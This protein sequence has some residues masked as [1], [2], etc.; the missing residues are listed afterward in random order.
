M[1]ILYSNGK[2]KALT[3]S[4]DDNQV[5][6]RKLLSMM[7]QYNLK[8]T[9]HVNAGTLAEREG[10]SEYITREEVK[11]LYHGHE[12][13]C[14]GY[15]HPFMGQLA[16][17]ELLYEILEEKKELEHLLGYPIRGM[18]YPF[19]EY[20]NA[21]EQTALSLGIEYSRTVEDTHHFGW[22]SEFMEWHPSFHHN[23]IMRDPSSVERF[24]NPPPYLNLPLLYI[25]GHSFEF[26]KQNTWEA[27]E[28]LCQSLSNQE[29]VWYA[30]NI[31]IKDYIA[32]V[33][34]LSFSADRKMVFNPSAVTIYYE[35]QGVMGEM[36]PGKVTRLLEG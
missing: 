13:A 9:F 14:H 21:V 16:K 25:W 24:L 30:T 11:A 6:D 23:D 7:N 17:G 33:R 5:Y 27:M 28:Q 2:K 31:E 15:H 8:G 12:V 1:K 29:D 35:E 4:Y 26:D 22:P 34:G 19:G 36:L 10:E 32:A 3:F 18:S 20:S